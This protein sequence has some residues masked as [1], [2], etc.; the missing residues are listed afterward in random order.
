[1]SDP[2]IP[3]PTNARPGDDF[4]EKSELATGAGT[5][6]GQSLMFEPAAE[7][8]D[9]PS[10]GKLYAGITDDPDILERGAIR[11]RPMTV[12]EEKILTTPRL[13]RSGQAL[14]MVFQNVIKSQGKGGQPINPGDLLSSDRVY[15]M[16]WLR[17]VSY[18]NEYKFNLTCPSAAC[19]KRFEYEVDL[20]EHPIDEMPDGAEEPFTYTLPFSKYEL[21]F[22]L[23]RGLD[24]MEI[25]KL[26][27]QP[28]K[29]NDTDESIVKRMSS[30][31]LAIKDPN[32]QELPHN[33]IE[34]FVESMRAGDASAFREEL[35][36]VD[37][38]IE[39]IKGIRCPHCDHEFDTPIP[40]T[41]NFFRTT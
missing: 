36:R 33:V 32:G 25:I 20:G 24:E 14:D 41:E 19:T 30:C 34:P 27:N 23:P 9:L 22:R 18:G 39:D 31:I 5:S 4:Y 29:M 38:G 35:A 26:Q 15:I 40:I 28:K 3:T 21:T 10:H 8:I 2:K 13:V 6:G 16:L 12:N 11:V 7:L 1:M 17:A 37:S